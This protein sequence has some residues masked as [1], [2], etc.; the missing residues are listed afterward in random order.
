MM[1]PFHVNFKL[2]FCALLMAWASMAML[3]PAH[4]KDFRNL[5][6]KTTLEHV[7]SK[8]GDNIKGVLFQDIASY[9]FPEQR[10]TLNNV[11]LN[12]PLYSTNVGLFDFYMDSNSGIMTIPALSI[13][14]FDD[15]AIAI[16]WYEK[17]NWDKSK[18]YQYVI[19]L[20]SQQNYLQAPLQ[21]LNVP[22]D[23]WKLDKY[24]NDVSHKILKSGIAFLLLH[25]LG[26]FHYR[27]AAYDIISNKQAQTQEKMSDSFALDV[28]ERMHTLPFG[29]VV[30]FSFTNLLDGGIATTHPVS[31]ERI[32]AI[33]SR[34]EYNPAIFISQENKNIYTVSDMLATAK[35]LR[36]IATTSLY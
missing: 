18:I 1:N 4:A 20:H 23:A 15:L 13:K 2:K 32:N 12:I 17:N 28:M 21:A 34:I 30:W 22:L 29:I 25:E 14:F 31:A 7:Q 35:E 3:T 5:Y 24:V 26:H 19:Q 6:P 11:R 36:R 27:H 10:Q 33:A 16:A 8:Y 9:L